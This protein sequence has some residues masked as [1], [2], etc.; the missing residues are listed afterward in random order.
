MIWAGYILFAMLALRFLVVVANFLTRPFLPK[1][2][3]LED[4]PLVSLLIP[5]R[6]EEKNLSNILVDLEKSDYSNFEVIVCNDHSTDGTR[7]VLDESQQHFS[8]LSF[9]D[10]DDL[11][12]G[13]KGKN[14][15]CYQLACRAKG[16]YMLFLDADVRFSPGFISRAVAYAEKNRLHLLSM[17]PRQEII[18]RG[19]WL[20]V[21][22]MNWI[23]L[24]F[25]PLRLVR[26]KWFSSLSAA[27]G[28]MMLFNA[29]SYRK[30]TWH[31]RLKDAM[32]EDISIARAMK[33]KHLPIAVLLGSNDISCRMY[34]GFGEAIHGFSRNVHQY[35]GG[36]RMWLTFYNLAAWLRLPLVLFFV[37]P[38]LAFAGLLMVF[39]MKWMVSAISYQ[40]VI[41]NLALHINQMVVF[42]FISYQNI[43][44]SIKGKVE[45][46]GRTYIS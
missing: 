39:L 3:Y 19:E 40:P 5:A 35:F 26:L 4:E 14:F 28:Q 27:N 16:R 15:A 41:K 11:P 17:F 30:H 43:L 8:R 42:L 13:W 12:E 32:V 2:Q 18:S 46:K 38:T 31:E 25:L 22:L 7:K 10:N 36:N 6:N 33:N 1:K 44:N 23:L 9:F 29:E 21:P 37:S 20:T 45:W 24:S 34:S